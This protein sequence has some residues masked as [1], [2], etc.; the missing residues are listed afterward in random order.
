MKTIIVTEKDQIAYVKLNRPDVRNAFNSDMIA[1]LTETFVKLQGRFDIR[2]VGLSGEGKVFC[3]GAD[4]NGMKSMVGFSVAENKR[5]SEKLYELF[6]ALSNLDLP[7]VAIIQGAVFGGAL[8]LIS[9]CDYVISD[10][11]TKFCFSEVKL[12]IAPAV[13]SGFVL[14]KATPQVQYYMA[15]ADLFNEL[16]AKELGL[17]NFVGSLDE[18]QKEFQ[19]VIQNYRNNGP[20]AVRRTKKLLRELSENT[21]EK[22]KN[23]TTQLIA[24]LRVSAEGQEGIMSFLENKNPTWKA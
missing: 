18:G 22:T 8:G 7:V 12:G 24:E 1:E 5:D 23:L 9:C 13:I 10:S 2:A 16:K 15:S 11:G 6:E 14:N 3:A 21:P 19:R 4:L 20:L 17:V